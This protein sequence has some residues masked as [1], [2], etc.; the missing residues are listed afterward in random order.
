MLRG[1]PRRGLSSRRPYTT[2]VRRTRAEGSAAST[3]ASPAS[4]EDLQYESSRALHP[5]VSQEHTSS[6]CSGHGLSTVE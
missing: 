3:A 2:L 1:T 6:E 4:F 5:C